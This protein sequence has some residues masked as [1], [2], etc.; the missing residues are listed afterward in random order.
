MPLPHILQITITANVIKA[1]SQ[2]VVTLETALGANV[3]PISIII[4]PVTTGGK[5]R[6]TFLIPIVFIMRA[7]IKYIAPATTIPPQAYGNFSASVSPA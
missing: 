5:K 3:K 7:S 2:L 1:K 6:M 4:G